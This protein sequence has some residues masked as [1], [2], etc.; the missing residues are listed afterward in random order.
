[1]SS[2]E[3]RP[4]TM[5]DAQA[6]VDV[7]VAA[8]QAAY[9][10]IVPEDQLN[11]QPT[12]QRLSKWR[13]AIEFGD[14]QVQ[15][16][17]YEGQ[18]V[19]FVAYDRSRDKGTKPTVGEIWAIH[20]LPT[21]WDGGCGLALWDAAREGLEDEDC[22]SVTVWIPLRNERA[23]R[24]FDLAGFKRELTTARTTPLGTIR[25]E[26]MRLKRALP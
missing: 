9:A 25:I 21:H 3:V 2:Y 10:G 8:T 24:F 5:R 18:V 6:I 4:A 22:T 23:L 15:V 1:M 26:E 20:V 14:P 12:A 7:H 16:A 11:I 13:E 19:G 17:V